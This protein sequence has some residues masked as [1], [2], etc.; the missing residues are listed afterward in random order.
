VAGSRRRQ[1][2]ARD[3]GPRAQLAARWDRCLPIGAARE[4][5]DDV[6]ALRALALR[7]QAELDAQ[8][9]QIRQ[10]EEFVRLLRHQRFGSPS[11][12][13]RG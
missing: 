2:R 4:L 5:P 13:S 3:D 6:D 1:S 12:S 9:A 10:L 11:A 7:Q 8:A